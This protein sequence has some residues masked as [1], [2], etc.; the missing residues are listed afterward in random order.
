MGNFSSNDLSPS[1]PPGAQ[2]K[3]FN[4]KQTKQLNQYFDE[5]FQQ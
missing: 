2:L 3:K 1:S 5:L 4:K